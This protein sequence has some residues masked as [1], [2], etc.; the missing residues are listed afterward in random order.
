MSPQGH[1]VPAPMSPQGQNAVA[2]NTENVPANVPAGTRVL[3]NNVPAVTRNVF[4]NISAS[5]RRKALEVWG[6]VECSNE[7]PIHGPQA[8]LYVALHVPDTN[9]P[10]G[11]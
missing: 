7:E 8:P 9:V 3:P 1:E 5:N 2:K 4:T 10:S 11:T 6:C